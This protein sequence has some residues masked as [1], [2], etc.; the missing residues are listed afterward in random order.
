MYVPLTE[1]CMLM[2]PKGMR[3]LNSGVGTSSAEHPDSSD[4]MLGRLQA[5]DVDH[6]KLA[7]V[8]HQTTPLSTGLLA[9][10]GGLVFSGDMDPSL[11]AFDAASGELLWRAELDDL[12]SSSLITYSVNDT[13]Y[14]AVVVGFK[15]FHIQG[16]L[17][18]FNQVRTKL[19]LPRL[20]PPK[21]GAS[22][23]VFA[24]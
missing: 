11:K 20:D 19:D 23:W 1:S 17:G 2:G 22:I 13:Q 8:H 6:Q 5:I 7:W 21:G 24:L 18:D 4:G 10:A 9:T 12:P 16:L 15:N 3:L 14:V